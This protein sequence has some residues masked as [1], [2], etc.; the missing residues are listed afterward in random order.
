M[1]L[2][3]RRNKLLPMVLVDL[4]NSN[5]KQ[6]FD[7]LALFAEDGTPIDPE[8]LI[9]GS[10]GVIPSNQIPR[11]SGVAFP[12][13]TI[14]P[15]PGSGRRYASFPGFTISAEGE[16]VVVERI[17]S[18]HT[19][20]DSTL[21]VKRSRD[22][23]SWTSGQ[24]VHTPADPTN[25][26]VRDPCLYR[27]P[28]TERIYLTYVDY[29][30]SGP[31]DWKS[32]IRYSDDGGRTFSAPIAVP[33]ARGSGQP[34]RRN[35]DGV[36]RWPGFK[37]TVNPFTAHV[38]ETTNPIDGAS[39]TLRTLFST[40]GVDRQEWDYV[41]VTPNLWLAAIRSTGNQS[42]SA[43]MSVSISTDKGATWS[44]PVALNKPSGILYDGWP[45]PVLFTD[46]SV[47][48]F[49]RGTNGLRLVVCLD[50]TAANLV[51][52]NMWAEPGNLLGQNWRPLDYIQGTNGIPIGKFQPVRVGDC[53]FGAY[54]AELDLV[55]D[56]AETRL[57][58]F[59]ERDLRV[60]RFYSSPAQSN[61]GQ[62]AN[63][64]NALPTISAKAQIRTNGGRFRVALSLKHNQPSGTLKTVLF[65]VAHTGKRWAGSA[66][67][68]DV[69]QPL[70]FP[71]RTSVESGTSVVAWNYF[72]NNDDVIELGP[73]V[74][75]FELVTQMSDTTVGRSMSE[76]KLTVEPV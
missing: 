36:Y 51:D 47:G 48:I 52:P 25:Y 67:V 29:K 41:E 22:G 23:R 71:L 21:Q 61:V 59:N 5:P 44:D 7:R 56:K 9:G 62:P 8:L 34:I 18:G 27:E 60:K 24:L 74:H 2:Q 16:F 17:A 76:I 49:V 54:Y 33:A 46:G 53:W 28:G 64:W 72:T 70:G 73:G 66:I 4:E 6:P 55:R 65:D 15:D 40:P 43:Q 75:T 50:P 12:Y 14:T 63:V 30:A 19:N 45:T 68:D 10:A 69:N 11:P 35:S 31:A 42:T 38:L 57:G 3:D 32:Q 26:D 39:W 1:S 58:I 37:I 20:L 13:S